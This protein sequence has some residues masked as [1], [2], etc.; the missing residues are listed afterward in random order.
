VAGGLCAFGAARSRCVSA[1]KARPGGEESAIA[2]ACA[3]AAA[4]VVFCDT[5]SYAQ[6]QDKKAAA[7]PVATVKAER[8]AIEQTR[9]FV[10]RV[11]AIN[12]VDVRARVQGYLDEVLF[13]EGDLVRA[14]SPLYRI[15]KGL[16]EAAVGQA[17][18]ALERSK[19]AKILTA[20]QLQR[21][22]E[23]LVKSAGTVVARDQ[24]IAAD[25]Q[26]GGAIITDEANLATAKINLG[27]TEIT[28]P[29]TG[30]IGKTN[31][32][33]GNVVGPDSGVLALI[34]S[35]DPIYVTFPVSQREFLRIQSGEERVDRQLAKVRIRFAD[36]RTYEQVGQINFVDVIVD[37][38]TDTILVRAT[39]P[40]PKGILT[41]GQLVRVDVQSG[42][43]HEKVVVPQAALIADQQGV[44]V[45]VVEDG[46]AEVRRLKVGAETAGNIVVEEGL[47]GGEQ[48]VVEGLQNLRPGAPVSATALRS[49]LD[50][51]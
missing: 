14:G 23:L 18:G 33:K 45:F 6:G 11:D 17:K 7:L 5:G 12:R 51:S 20:V 9:D 35:Q 19:A 27:Y 31:V 22:E 36:G 29:I 30:R 48:V 50:R 26:A 37:R 8:Q 13:K 43:Q 21:A 34:V 32:T 49:A 46:K 1:M 40:N 41:D 38:S 4:V 47:S 10:G 2:L 3:V 25:R 42:A 24:A 15:E 44:Y 28:A 16:F 39:F